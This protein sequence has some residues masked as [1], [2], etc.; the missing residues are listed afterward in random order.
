MSSLVCV[1]DKGVKR[2]KS[3]YLDLSFEHQDV[4]VG[5]FTGFFD[6]SCNSFKLGQSNSIDFSASFLL[7]LF[8][9]EQQIPKRWLLAINNIVE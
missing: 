1:F 3:N 5:T 6:F 8:F 7:K 2:Y 9:D 4:K